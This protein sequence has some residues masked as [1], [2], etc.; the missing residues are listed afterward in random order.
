VSA[1]PGVFSTRGPAFVASVFRIGLDV[2][3]RL[4]RRLELAGSH[5]FHLQ[6]GGPVRAPED[7]S[8]NTFLLRLVANP[9]GS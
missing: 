5:Q 3:W 4:S 9:A 8:R 1:A 7:V 2:A 6:S